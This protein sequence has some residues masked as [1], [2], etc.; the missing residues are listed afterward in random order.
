MLPGAFNR[1][2]SMAERMAA[3]QI[4]RSADALKY[5]HRESF[6]GRW[7]GFAIAVLAMIGA[8]AT[9]A[10]NQ[11]WLAAAFL[12]VPVTGVAKVLINQP[13][14]RCTLTE[15]LL[16]LSNPPP[17]MPLPLARHRMRQHRIELHQVLLTFETRR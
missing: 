15:A 2:L 16:F 9:A 11:P 8:G 10:M 17:P 12:G 5:Q 4:S 1:L 7:L 6:A 13:I 14:G 3:A